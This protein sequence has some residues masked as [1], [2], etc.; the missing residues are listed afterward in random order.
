MKTPRVLRLFGA[1]AIAACLVVLPTSAREKKPAEPVDLYL[2][3]KVPS[4]IG[5]LIRHDE[6]ADIF[7]SRVFESFRAS[8]YKGR[9]DDDDSAKPTGAQ[10]L[11]EFNILEW[12]PDHVGNITCTFTASLVREN[13]KPVRLGVFTT[14]SMRLGS[15]SLGASSAYEDSAKDALRDL[16]RKLEKDRLLPEKSETNPE[17]KPAAK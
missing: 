4:L 11:I 6:V 15:G 1:A 12:R 14:S 10:R 16:Y 3:V 8:G 7:V 5:D 2:S 9:M 13:E 17:P